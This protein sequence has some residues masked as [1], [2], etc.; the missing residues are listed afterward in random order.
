MQLKTE[1]IGPEAAERPEIVIENDFRSMALSDLWQ[2]VTRHEL[3]WTFAL[4]EVKQRFRRSVLGP[5]W[6]TLS[7]GIMIAALSFVMSQVFEQ[8]LGAYVPYFATGMIFWTLLVSVITEGCTSFVDSEGYIKN[9]PMPLSVH[10]YRM[11]AR[12]VIVWLHNMIIY[13]AVFAI[14]I[15]SVDMNFLA[16]IPGFLLF[17]GTIIT[18]AFIL[19]IVSTRYRDLSQIVISGLQVVFFVTPVFWSVEALPKRQAFVEWNP[20]FHLMQLVRAPLIGQWPDT[21]SW[22]VTAVILFI[23]VFVAGGLYRR[24]YARIPYWI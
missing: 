23:L 19:A 10:F 21:K 5:F 7:T 9:V 12:N 20:L 18:A 24:T 4:H 16:F 14:F 8:D 13:V 1:T 17:L 6:I 2:G 15:H 3:W 22:I 11:I